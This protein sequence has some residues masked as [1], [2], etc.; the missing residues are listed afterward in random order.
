ML[1]G[2]KLYVLFS[3]DQQRNSPTFQNSS[4]PEFKWLL[5]FVLWQSNHLEI[6]LWPNI[7]TEKFSSLPWSSTSGWPW[8]QEAD[9][10]RVNFTANDIG[11]SSWQSAFI[12]VPSTTALHTASV[13]TNQLLY[14]RINT[15]NIIWQT[16]CTANMHSPGGSTRV[17]PGMVK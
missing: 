15:Y 8:Y 12:S 16:S 1:Y 5:K 2:W 3:P 4:I 17:H 6:S 11:F 13:H 14:T 7:H 9:R 10:L